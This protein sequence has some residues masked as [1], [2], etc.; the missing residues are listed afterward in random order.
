MTTFLNELHHI[1]SREAAE[2]IDDPVRMGDM[3]GELS[4]ALG[5][6]IA[7]AARGDAR[8]ISVLTSEATKRIA[9][10]AEHKAA[11]QEHTPGS[12]IISFN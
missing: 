11:A 8:V 2:S 7:I 12:P 10:T 6:A 9:E 4:E 3:L 5:T 1:L